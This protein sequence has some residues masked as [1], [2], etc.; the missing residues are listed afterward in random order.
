MIL[1]HIRIF[2]LFLN[3]STADCNEKYETHGAIDVTC[4]VTSVAPSTANMETGQPF[5]RSAEEVMAPS[6]I[7]SHISQRR[8]KLAIAFW[9]NLGKST[10]MYL[11]EFDRITKPKRF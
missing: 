11:T 4:A 7:V 2:E 1:I 6:L 10:V 5:A 8:R 3:R 9:A